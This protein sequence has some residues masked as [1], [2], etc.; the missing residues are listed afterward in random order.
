MRHRTPT[1]LLA[2]ALLVPCASALAGSHWRG[3]MHNGKFWKKSDVREALR[4]TDDEVH[5][6]DRIFAKDQS[7]LK[8]LKAEVEKRRDDLDA[9]LV[10]DEVGDEQ[11]LDQVDRLEQARARLGKARA[12]MVL[13]M[14]PLEQEVLKCVSLNTKHQVIKIVDVHQGSLNSSLVRTADVFRETAVAGKHEFLRSRIA[15]VLG[16]DCDDLDLRAAAGPAILFYNAVVCG[17]PIDA[18]AMADQLT[19][20]VFAP[21]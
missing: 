21:R 6:L 2:A 17:Q 5:S 15:A 18:E 14:R 8:D 3:A 13:E 10:P 11:V 19:N 9:L 7:N 16:D 20:L 4:L 12:L 1:L